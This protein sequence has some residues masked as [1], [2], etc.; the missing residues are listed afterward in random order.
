M[1]ANWDYVKDTTLWPY[2][3]LIEKLQA[4]LAYSFIQ[5]YYTHTMPQAAAFLQ[6]LIL[7]A[8][9]ERNP[10]WSQVTATFAHLHAAGVQD[11][12]DLVARVATRAQCLSFLAHNGLAFPHLID[13]LNCLLR[14]TLPFA[15]ATRELLKHDDPQEMA[16]Y[17]A[18][19]QRRLTESFSL[20]E[21]GRLHAERIVLIQ[22]TGLPEAFVIQ[23]VHRADIARLPLCGAGYDTL[24]KIAAAD[25]P[26]ME[27]AMNAYFLRTQGKSWKAFKSVILLRGL[28]RGA[29]ALPAIVEA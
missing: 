29:Q 25:L 7:P 15:T 5:Q 16:Y 19:K 18:L 20:L 12:A 22:A 1:H 28:I 2:E 26:E 13:V 21:R 14:W 8:E 27:A 10:Y 11:Y 9:W 4:V 17:L 23:I 6:R 24:A 3:A